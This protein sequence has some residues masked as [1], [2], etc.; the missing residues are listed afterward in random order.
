MSYNSSVIIQSYLIAL[1]SL[2]INIRGTPYT[3]IFFLRGTAFPHEKK[4]GEKGQEQ[5]CNNYKIIKW[6]E[7]F[8]AINNWPCI[9]PAKRT[10]LPNAIQAAYSG[11]EH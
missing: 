3:D 10:S 1:L 9:Y 8:P 11:E 2:C 4:S 5:Q 6:V 7:V